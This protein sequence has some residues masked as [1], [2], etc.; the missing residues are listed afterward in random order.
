MEFYAYHGCYREEQLIGNN[1]LVDITMD[2][3]MGKASKS[4]DLSDALNYAEVYELVKQEM[5]IRS[6][7]L[8]HVSARILD[9]LFECFPQ[10]ER[11][12]VCVAKLNP[13]V[14]GQIRSVCVC[15]QRTRTKD[16]DACTV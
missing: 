1:F 16:I 2:T 7:L 15:Q 5:T 3:D 11:A 13:P 10:L 6:H 14:G 4:D 12:E 8:E 9:R